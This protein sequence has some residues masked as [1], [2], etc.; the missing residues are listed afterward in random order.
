MT[1]SVPDQSINLKIHSN[2]HYEDVSLLNFFLD[3]DVIPI[4]I[5]FERDT[6]HSELVDIFESIK[7][8]IGSPRNYELSKEE[9][10]EIHRLKQ[11]IERKKAAEKTE[12]ERV[13]ALEE[14]E[15]K[16]EKI[17]EWVRKIF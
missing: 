10:E 9:Q 11:E 7:S 12:E 14:L 17:K 4:E 5:T 15:A 1:Q 16:E 6:T 8:K 13:K 3:H 2:S